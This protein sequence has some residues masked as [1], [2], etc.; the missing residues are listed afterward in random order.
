MKGSQRFKGLTLTAADRKELRRRAGAGKKWTARVWRRMQSLQ[1]LDRGMTLT[2][3]AAALGTFRR[4]VSR[5]ASRYLDQGLEHALSEEPRPKQAT[6]LDSTQQAALVAMACGPPPEGD[7]RWTLRSLAK[8]AVRRGVT[9]RIGKETIRV[10]LAEHKL[11]PWREKNV[12]RAGAQRRVRRADGG[13]S[14]AVRASVQLEGTGRRT[15]RAART[16]A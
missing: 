15:R 16:T 9:D 8:H 11:K 5:V 13:R 4:E 2:A 6:K 3:T 14:A 7:A 12:V 1:M 10:I